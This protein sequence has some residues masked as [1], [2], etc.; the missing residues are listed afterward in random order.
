MPS[1]Q[2]FADTRERC[3]RIADYCAE[4]GWDPQTLRYSLLTYGADVKAMYASANAFEDL[5]GRYQAIQ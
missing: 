2:I 5:V 4:I 1:S 3:E